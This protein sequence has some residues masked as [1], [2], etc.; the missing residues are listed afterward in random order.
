MSARYFNTV[1]LLILLIFPAKQIVSADS[2]L[3]APRSQKLQAAFTNQFLKFVSWDPE[4]IQD[5][6]VLCVL[7]DKDGLTKE[8]LALNGKVTIWGNLQVKT[9]GAAITLTEL[10]DC[11]GVYVDTGFPY[12]ALKA[13]IK[14]ERLLTLVR[15]DFDDTDLGIFVFL[16]HDNKLRFKVNLKQAKKKGIQVNAS[17]LL[18]AVEVIEG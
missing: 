1:F 14:Q 18:L 15:D 12:Q 13:S 9:Y 2:T 4:Y 6:F 17:L 3:D 10:A 16:L 8:M 7:S 5:S 11:K